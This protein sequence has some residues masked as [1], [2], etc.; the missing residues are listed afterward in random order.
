MSFAAAAALGGVS[1]LTI[2]LGLP[3]ARWG[4]PG[5]RLMSF[6]TAASVGVLLFIF[7]DVLRNA[8]SVIEA[9]MATSAAGGAA[10]GLLLAVGIAIGLLSLVMFEQLSRRRRPTLPAGPGAMAVP[11]AAPSRIP[12]SA[13]L[14]TA[15]LIAI[16]I[17]LHNFSEGLAIGQ[18]AA[19]GAY[20][21]FLLLVIG[22]GLHN[23]TEGFGISGPMLGRK[24]SW[25]FL[26]LLGLVGGG[27][28]FLGTVMGYGVT[29]AV[30]GGS[31][32]SE[33]VSV[34]FLALAAG[35]ILYVV[36]ELQHVGRK[37]GSHEVGMAGLLAGLLAGFGTD[38][39]LKSIGG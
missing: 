35:A 15:L 16:G 36:G 21:F 18:S 6:L 20:R 26:A 33:A 13:P 12:L 31:T 9:R 27:P 37:L 17:G 19:Q 34:L 4:R 32:A 3:I 30:G 29:T 7:Y 22:F 2:M 39:L 25:R 38:L 1:G 23:I 24:P 14:R 5:P 11:A 8:S 10:F 28:T